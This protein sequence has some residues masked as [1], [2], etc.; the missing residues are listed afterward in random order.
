MATESTMTELGSLS[1]NTSFSA[2]TPTLTNSSCTPDADADADASSNAASLSL[3]S[4]PPTTASPDS[5]SLSLDPVDIRLPKQECLIAPLLDAAIP[6]LKSAQ[7]AIEE[8]QRDTILDSLD[9]RDDQ[10]EL[11]SGQ[12]TPMG[13]AIVV[14]LLPPAPTP[15]P[16][17]S[18]SP[19]SAP[20]PTSTGRAR[21][22][23]ASMPVYNIAKLSGTDAHGKR[24]AKGDIV[25]VQKRRRTLHH[26]AFDIAPKSN[27][28]TSSTDAL[29]MDDQS[30]EDGIVA[31]SPYDGPPPSPNAKTARP[32]K[33]YK[34]KAAAAAAAAMVPRATRLSGAP[35]ESLATKLSALGKRARDQFEKGIKKMPRELRRLKDTDEFAHI[36]TRP[37]RHTVWS[38]GKYVDP[39]E[40]EEAA[41][42]PPRKK[43]K[44]EESVAAKSDH[45]H[46]EEKSI[47]A[48]PVAPASK[49]PH[50]KIWAEKGLYAGQEMPLDMIKAMKLTAPERKKL[51][52]HP[53]LIPSD[54]PNRVLPMPW[55]GGLRALINGRGFKLP[56]DICNPLLPGQ[57]KPPA[58]RTMTK[59]RFVGD[60]AAY[61][62]KTPHVGDFASKCVCKP[63][64]GCAEDCQNRIMLYEC[65]E[66]NC[67]V[68]K[69]YCQNRAFQNLSARTKQG[70]RYRV[71]VEVLKT[72]DR[73]Y[74]V[75]SNRFFEP[76]EIIMEYT[77]EIIT[78]EECERRMNEEYKDNEC[79]YLM[80]FDQNMIIDATT[81]SIARFV[82]HS[83]SPNCRMIKWIVSGQPRMALFAGDRPIQTGD[84]LTYDYNFDP[85]SAKNVQKCLCGS[86]NCRG[87]LGPK[88]KEAKPPKAPKEVKSVRGSVKAGKRKLKELLAGGDGSD[89]KA[90]KK[91]KVV[92]KTKASFSAKGLKAAKGAATAIKRSASSISVSATTAIGAAKK[93][94]RAYVRRSTTNVLTKTKTYS[95]KGSPK[96]SVSSRSSSLTTIVAAGSATDKSA[97]AKPAV[98]KRTPKKSAKNSTSKETPASSAVKASVS[99]S[100]RKRTP[101]WKA[102]HADDGDDDYSPVPWK[103]SRKGLELPRASKIRL[104]Q[105]E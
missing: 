68:G 101:S 102:L 94:K 19:T 25:G 16:T 88:P 20:P 24:R 93:T 46:E 63:E 29:P 79:Y 78:D 98:T 51:A 37:I 90:T 18:P 17:P 58:Y 72:S 85:F 5:M 28:N 43:A 44:R 70:G 23:P 27:N 33:K 89:G 74:G 50:V 54:Q 62:K 15:T 36:D 7:L 22:A 64:D 60:A 21:R 14:E 45:D 2:T 81:G 100:A 105:D 96:V 13:S 103:K 59:N 77:G 86:P 34:T 104:V 47:E 11:F 97:K 26:S 71:G 6:L 53:E 8:Q 80:S 95:K 69:A 12:Q 76:N 42:A 67:N 92:K 3:S 61:W 4:T 84:E 48:E 38:K 55:F 73:G 56:F 49:R 10:E 35:A 66:A 30:M 91:L 9:S 82:N 41:D 65:D 57:P 1:A 52:S 40:L 99:S 83:C 39:D 87:V 31:A 32:V 75:R